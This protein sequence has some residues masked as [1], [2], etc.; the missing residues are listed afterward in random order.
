MALLF[1]GFMLFVLLRNPN[2]VVL[3]L[4]EQRNLFFRLW[5]LL[6]AVGISAGIGEIFFYR[7][8]FSESA[9]EERTKFLRKKFRPYSEIETVEYRPG[10]IFQPAFLTI[11]FSDLR[12][13]KMFSGLYNLET[14]GRIFVTYGNKSIIMTSK[15]VKH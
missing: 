4:W 1:L 10:T 13:I 9:I 2:Q 12:T 15:E 5:M 8:V 6:C 11:I 3:E 7:M 14:V